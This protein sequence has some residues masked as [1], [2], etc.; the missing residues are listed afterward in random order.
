MRSESS[1]TSL[2]WIPKG[3]VEGVFR[4]PFELGVAH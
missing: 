2:S 1:I 4:L 3:A